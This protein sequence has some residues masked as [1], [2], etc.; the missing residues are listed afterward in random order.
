MS[1]TFAQVSHDDLARLVAETPLAWIV[2]H[3]APHSALLMPVLLERDGEG[4]PTSLLGHLPLGAPATNALASDARA[5]FLFLG[6]NRYIPPSMAGERDWAPT[7]NFVSARIEAAVGLAADLTR[8]AVESLTNHLEGP[9]GWSPSE[10]GPR[11]AD[12]L[13]RI[14]GF[15]ASIAA[16]S[17][18]FK[19]GQDE[20][21]HVRQNI[22]E[23]LD[24]TPLGEWTGRSAAR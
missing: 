15:R 13:A 6:P 24:G 10:L 17:P 11:Y 9:D 8:E 1:A 20:S 4:R 12:L 14:V 7:W 3:A 2:P 23:G 21:T 18:R 16:I 19:L 22:A 5:G